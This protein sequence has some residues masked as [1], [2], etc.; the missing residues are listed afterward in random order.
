MCKPA[1]E[2]DS[3]V[4][5]IDMRA[6]IDHRSQDE[7]KNQ[8]QVFEEQQEVR[9]GRSSYRSGLMSPRFK[10]A[11]GGLSGLALR[12]PRRRDE[13]HSCRS[14]EG[15]IG[16]QTSRTNEQRHDVL[17]Q[18][19][20]SQHSSIKETKDRSY[21]GGIIDLFSDRSSPPG[22]PFVRRD[23]SL[24][25]RSNQDN[26]ARV[27]P[28][29]NSCDGSMSVQE[30]DNIMRVRIK[31]GYEEHVL[32]HGN[33]AEE[34]N[35]RIRLE[36]GLDG[37]MLNTT[38]AIL[39]MN[40]ED[41]LKLSRVH[42]NGNADLKDKEKWLKGEEQWITEQIKIE[43][44]VRLRQE[45]EEQHWCRQREKIKEQQDAIV[46]KEALELYCTR[47]GFPTIHEP[48]KQGCVWR[49]TRAP[50]TY[51]LHNAAM[52]ND[53]RIVEML[54]QEGASTLQRDSAGLTAEQVASKRNRHGSHDEVI[55]MLQAPS[56]KF[57][58]HKQIYV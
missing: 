53:I 45:R 38:E 18:R 19:S 7:I 35:Q 4:V 47:H 52:N 22:S 23:L 15:S 33:R 31:E 9:S 34:T 37:K 49:P 58:G 10:G 48:R 32:S 27:R 55:R 8:T 42:I 16:S 30:K 36:N 21:A 54:L 51:A 56:P 57:G 29:E 1:P 26:N 24:S 39:Q 44:E 12:S 5:A 25:Q 2:V 13:V 40:R 14:R 17:S 11:L 20:M 43:E 28:R 41:L 50:T 6:V 3:E 46:R